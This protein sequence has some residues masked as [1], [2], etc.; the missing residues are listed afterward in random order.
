[1][2]NLDTVAHGIEY[3]TRVF[4]GVGGHSRE[5]Y[6]GTSHD[7]AAHL[8]GRN[9]ANDLYAA[10]AEFPNEAI[11]SQVA[12]YLLKTGL[13]EEK[14]EPD[15]SRQRNQVFMYRIPKVLSFRE[16]LDRKAREEDQNGLRKRKEE[17]IASVRRLV[18]QIQAWLQEADLDHKLEVT[19]FLPMKVEQGL[20]AYHALGLRITL[21]GSTVEVIPV[22]RNIVGAVGPRGDVGLRAEGRVDITDGARKY[23]LF[24]T[25]GDRERWFVVDERYEAS[26]LERDRFLAILEDLLS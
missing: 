8:S 6:V 21:A 4:Q 1:M 23:M 12:E 11:A 2:P 18:E 7:A 20:G 10:T 24:R 14:N 5:W 25:L 16:F 13:R 3:F 17:W 15:Q 26:E 19:S 22:G 9:L